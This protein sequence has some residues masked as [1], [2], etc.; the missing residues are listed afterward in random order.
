MAIGINNE[1]NRDQ[2]V[3]TK[4]L[5]LAHGTRIL[6]A[7]A[8]ERRYEQSC[9]HLNYVAQDFGA[10]D[11]TGDG[12]GLQQGS[13]DQSRLDIICDITDIPE[14]DESFDAILCTE[15]FEHLPDPLLALREFTRLIKP[16]G[17]LILTAPFNSLT[18]FAP[19]HFATG[20]SHYYFEQHLQKNGFE[21]LECTPN[22]NL[23]EFIG[24]EIQRIKKVAA[25]YAEDKPSIPERI[26]LRIV[27]N[28]LERFSMRDKGSQELLCFG[29]HI[30]ARK[31]PA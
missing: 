15:V 16:G 12:K 8:G 21:L 24:Q 11:G 22:G 1:H 10:Y 13:W 9:T 6:D 25:R 23:F 27:L 3:R 4:L 28:M 17:I 7:G 2:W 31:K 19:F 14:P 26:A 29:H 5:A 30:L 20:F 18:H